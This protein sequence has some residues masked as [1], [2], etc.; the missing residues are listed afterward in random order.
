MA[1]LR[2]RSS[3]RTLKRRTSKRKILK[4]KTP[5]RKTPK[6]RTPKRKT[7]RRKTQRR[8]TQRRKTQR[9][10]KLGGSSD[11]DGDAS[12]WR[13]K[14]KDAEKDVIIDGK[15][16]IVVHDDDDDEEDN[17]VY[18]F[19]ESLKENKKVGKY[20]PVSKKIYLNEG[21][22]VVDW[23][24]DLSVELPDLYSGNP[25]AESPEPESGFFSKADFDQGGLDLLKAMGFP[26]DDAKTALSQSGNNVERAAE[27]LLSDYPDTTAMIKRKSSVSDVSRKLEEI[28]Q[29]M[30]DLDQT[31]LMLAIE[32]VGADTDINIIV[33]KYI[34]LITQ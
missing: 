14:W 17:A 1:K 27:L 19:D 34:D 28:I 33:D 5:K 8:K 24:R 4:R 11:R 32:K 3:R 26:T 22:I 2:G 15:L 13:S 25:G 18:L 30:P 20:D 23:D 29:I 10:N 12:E 9:R 6:R 31:L 7:Q 21:A 16:Y